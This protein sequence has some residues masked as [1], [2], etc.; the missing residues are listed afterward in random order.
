MKNRLWFLFIILVFNLINAQ[1]EVFV[2]KEVDSLYKEDQFYI[3]A[4]YNLFGNKPKGLNQSGFSIGLNFGF[5]KD[6][7]INKNRN[8]AIGFG[9]GYSLNSYN[10]NL[11]V[12]E[13]SSDNFTYR[14]I[15]ETVGDFTKNKLTQHI[16]ELPIEYRWRT[17]TPQDYSF[18]RIYTGFKFGY[19][20]TSTTKFK[21]NL[22]DFNSGINND[23]NSFQYGLTFSAGYNTWNLHAYY[24]LNPIF[25]RSAKLD[26][27]S[28]D[29]NTIKIGLM[30]YIL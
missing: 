18:W 28:I 21:G 4:T 15:D 16:I 26:D 25:S 24:G 14:I 29:I 3:G 27:V 9:L 6:M 11:L 10:N 12:T 8:K 22:G 17:S 7:P 1:D 30:F 2:K 5:I 13:N 20:L 19:V 23:I